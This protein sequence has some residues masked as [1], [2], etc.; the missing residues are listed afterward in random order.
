[1]TAEPRTSQPWLSPSTPAAARHVHQAPLP[2]GGPGLAER[3]RAAERPSARPFGA[4][5][6][7]S[8]PM[9]AGGRQSVTFAGPGVRTPAVWPVVL[10]TLLVFFAGSISAA[11][12]ARKA[13]QMGMS[14]TPYWT[15]FGI[16]WAISMG[17]SLVVYLVE[18][19]AAG[20][21]TP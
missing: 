16:T 6:A 9:Q 12:R 5:P 13:E 8:Y 2:G 21:F 10:W 4:P 19:A 17:L 11:R 18:F 1:V 15:A 7:P 20:L 14:G 3:Y